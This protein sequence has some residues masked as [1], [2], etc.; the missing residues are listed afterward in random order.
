[1]Q[2]MVEFESSTPSSMENRHATEIT[3]KNCDFVTEPYS[4][5]VVLQVSC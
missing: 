1:M 2:E 5:I 4:A 3:D